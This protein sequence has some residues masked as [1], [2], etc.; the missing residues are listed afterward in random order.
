[1]N[2]NDIPATL[3]KK[4]PIEEALKLLG[5]FERSE[6]GLPKR[7]WGSIEVIAGPWIWNWKLLITIHKNSRD[8]IYIPQELCVGLTMR[9]IDILV[10][11]YCA[12]DSLFRKE[13]PPQEL[14]WG[15]IEWER[16]NK[17][18]RQEYERRPKIWADKDFFRF[19]ISLYE[20]EK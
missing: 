18:M 6:Y 14:M 5:F 7:T 1:M 19:C 8:V 4:L 20:N 3:T 11:I 9:P 17:K 10:I 16:C 15:K 2:Y 13:E 12:C